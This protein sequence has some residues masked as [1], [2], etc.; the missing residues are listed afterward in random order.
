MLEL[1]ELES[2][3]KNLLIV[4]SSPRV[5]VNTMIPTTMKDNCWDHI[6]MSMLKPNQ[7]TRMSNVCT[8]Q[9][10]LVRS[11]TCWSRYL[12]DGVHLPDAIE[13]D[14]DGGDEDLPDA[15]G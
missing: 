10:D 2:Q 8:I 4:R 6:S 7:L 11:R 9:E 15:V 13:H 3:M 5:E 14:V 1:F 12:S